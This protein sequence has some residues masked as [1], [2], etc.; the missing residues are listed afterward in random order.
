LFRCVGVGVAFW[1]QGRAVEAL[2]EVSLCAEAGEFLS[3][4]GPSG[5]GKTTLLRALG[6]L[7]QPSSGTVE[8]PGGRRPVLV[9][10]EASVFP[11]LTVLD[12]AAFGLEAMGVGREERERRALPLLRRVGLGGRERDYPGKLSTGMKQR[13]ALVQAFLA[14]PELLLLDE[15]FAALDCQTR[16]QLQDE[17][18]D[19]W[20]QQTRTVILVTHDVDEA[21]RLSDRVLVMS[22]QPGRVVAEVK[23]GLGRPRGVETLVNSAFLERKREVLRHLGFGVKDMAHAAGR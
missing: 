3:I 19:L 15:P 11:W 18:L 2:R 16:W 9:R 21:I 10:Q 1:S 12:N 6:G 5:C 4:V 7:M 22:A 17:L 13:V 14:E 20:E 8:Q 23:I